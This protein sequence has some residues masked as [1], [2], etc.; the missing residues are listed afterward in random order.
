[1]EQRFTFLHNFQI[2]FFAFHTMVRWQQHPILHFYN[3]LHPCISMCILYTDLYKIP[4][5][6]TGVFVHSDQGLLQLVM[7][8]CI[9]AALMS[10]SLVKL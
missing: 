2:A 7:T 10:N 1:M 9:L 8:S 6:L 5:V 4:I 3:P